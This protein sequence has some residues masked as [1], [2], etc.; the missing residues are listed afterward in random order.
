MIL[1]FSF[2]FGKL[3]FSRKL[4]AGFERKWFGKKFSTEIL[5]YDRQIDPL[6]RRKFGRVILEYL[7]NLFDKPAT[8]SNK[9]LNWNI[10]LFIN[11]WTVDDSQSWLVHFLRN[12]HFIYFLHFFPRR[13]TY[14]RKADFGVG[15][16]CLGSN[17]KRGNLVTS[18]KRE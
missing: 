1:A 9:Y 7:M 2:F 6:L 18:R 15:W 14:C 11:L 16:K 4:H 3:I 5:W 8:E 17:K 13:L 12:M 10:Y